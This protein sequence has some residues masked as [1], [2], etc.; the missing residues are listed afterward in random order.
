M[1][2]R[3]RW[4]YVVEHVAFFTTGVLNDRGSEGWELVAAVPV[5]T[6]EHANRK[7]ELQLIFKRP[8]PGM[9]R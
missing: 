3:Q 2:Q 5:V 4:E 9:T 7:T 1:S 6:G 8:A